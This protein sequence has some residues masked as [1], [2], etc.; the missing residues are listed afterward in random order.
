M[1]NKLDARRR[2]HGVIFI[3][4]LSLPNSL[5]SR[6]LVR[7]LCHR[8]SFHAFTLSLQDRRT[9]RYFVKISNHPLFHDPDTVGVRITMERSKKFF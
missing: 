5:F 3:V 8:R 9:F 2:C 1:K 4:L 7:M 6:R